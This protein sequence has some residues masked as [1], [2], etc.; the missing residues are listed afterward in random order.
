M[1]EKDSIDLKSLASS[2]K[3]FVAL[4]EAEVKLRRIEIMLHENFPSSLLSSKS[5]P[6]KAFDDFYDDFANGI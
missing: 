1:S 3:K 2:F 4:K 6:Q 5:S